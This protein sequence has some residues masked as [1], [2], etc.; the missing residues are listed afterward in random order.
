MRNKIVGLYFEIISN[1][2]EHC[3][4]CYN[5]KLIQYDYSIDYE[6]FKKT[7]SDSKTLGC[8][9]VV[10][11]GGEPFLHV[12]LLRFLDILI[13]NNM[14]TT[15]VT[16]LTI[17]HKEIYQYL[18]EVPVVLQVTLDG[19]VAAVHDFTRGKGTFERV[20]V[21]LN[22]LLEMG[23]K[24]TVQLRMNLHKENWRY[25][26][27]VVAL[28]DRLGINY[29]NLALINP[30]GGGRGFCENIIQS[31]DEGILFEI[32]NE[33]NRIKKKYICEIIFEG[34]KESIGCPYYG[35][36]NINCGLRI[37]PSGDVYPCQLFTDKIFSLGNI[38]CS[39][40]EDII[41]GDS[42]KDFLQLMSLRQKYINECARCAY[43]SMCNGGCPAEAY[44]FKENIF[45]TN[46]KCSRNITLF[47]KY[48]KKILDVNN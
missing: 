9:S 12:D 5:E 24:G 39:P 16:N 28:A 44:N 3:L 18:C 35:R 29:V 15:I 41:N 31:E 37:S 2:N 25:I 14:R 42:M 34:L 40:L 11:S 23:F 45:S 7:I 46:G 26:E 6:I 21:N 17:Y 38:K 47:N 8:D 4:Y 27:D 30:V 10:L 36:D 20:I 22:R 33:V 48:I 13:T 19:P 43:K 1:C 32:Q